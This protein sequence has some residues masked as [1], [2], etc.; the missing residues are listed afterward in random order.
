MIPKM[1]LYITDTQPAN[2]KVIEQLSVFASRI[3]ASLH[4]L[5]IHLNKTKDQVL[6]HL[7]GIAE[8]II[9]EKQKILICISQSVAFQYLEDG[10]Y[11][12]QKLVQQTEH[13]I[14]LNPEQ[15]NRLFYPAI[16]V[17][18]PKSACEISKEDVRKS[19]LNKISLDIS[20]FEL[21][22]GD[23]WDYRADLIDPE[24]CIR[25]THLGYNAVEQLP[26]QL[27]SQEIKQLL[28]DP[29]VMGYL[30]MK[31]LANQ[32]TI[33]IGSVPAWKSYGFLSELLFAQQDNQSIVA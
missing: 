10:L 15:L 22:E 7:G 26:K 2:E 30:N 9:S 25:Y 8:A 5:S 19:W 18:M 6:S 31:Q 33:L 13:M 3:G 14:M 20:I 16:G 21:D 32:L 27:E 17:C 11:F 23:Q 1:L 24:L 12:F 4:P 29:Q 28:V